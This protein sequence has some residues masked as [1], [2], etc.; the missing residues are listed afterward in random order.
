MQERKEKPKRGRLGREQPLPPPSPPSPSQSPF[1]CI[2]G[3]WRFALCRRRCFQGRPLRPKRGCLKPPPSPVKCCDTPFSF[4]SPSTSR[5]LSLS[6]LFYFPSLP[7]SPTFPYL[8][9]PF[10]LL[11]SRSSLLV[12][13]LFLLTPL[14]LSPRPA[15]ASAVSVPPCSSASVAAEEE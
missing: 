15:T 7:F 3:C 13:P 9:S 6:F 10:P 12:Y 1:T 14:L 5:P 2:H 11:S 4:S 8:I